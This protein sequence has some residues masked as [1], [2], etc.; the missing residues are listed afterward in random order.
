MVWVCASMLLWRIP[1]KLHNYP[2]TRGTAP[3]DKARVVCAGTSPLT[4]VRAQRSPPPPIWSF[5]FTLD[6]GG[7]DLLKWS[8]DWIDR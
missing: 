3:D 5:F 4:A 7:L 6:P 1:T 8:M 2:P